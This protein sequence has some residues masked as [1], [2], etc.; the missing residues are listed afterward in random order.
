VFLSRL[1]RNVGEFRRMPTATVN[2]MASAADSNDPF[3]QRLVR[4][5]HTDAY[6]RHPKLL[7][8]PQFTHGVALCRLPPTFEEYFALIDG[9]ARRNCKKAAREGC[10]FRRIQPNDHLDD[11]REIRGSTDVRQGRPVPPEY[12]TGKVGPYTDPPSLNP[13]HD[14]PFFGVF[15]GEKM[16]AYGSC[17]IAGEVCLIQHILG[18]AGWLDKNVVPLLITEIA[19]YV[20]QHHPAV[21]FYGYDKYFGATETMR[22][23]KRKFGFVPYHVRWVLDDPAG[24]PMP[25]TGP[26]G[27]LPCK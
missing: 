20:R 13:Y 19:R 11:I 25:A 1:W 17:M 22:R 6:R 16:V 8:L 14:Y 5:F 10:T 3:Y 21:A 15:N 7:V 24:V 23:F 18:H 27:E 9:A 26:T 12:L 4:K 2:L